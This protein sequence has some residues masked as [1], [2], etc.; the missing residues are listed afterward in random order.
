M[1]AKDGCVPAH[2]L[3]SEV[4]WGFFHMEDNGNI[5]EIVRVAVLRKCPTLNVIM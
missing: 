2:F 3:G 5:E 1:I 4:I